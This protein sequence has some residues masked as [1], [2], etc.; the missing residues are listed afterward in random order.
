MKKIT[1]T[2]LF[3]I[4]VPSFAGLVQNGD[5]AC[6]KTIFN[7]NGNIIS[8]HNVKLNLRVNER[9]SAGVATVAIQDIEKKV[10]L[11]EYESGGDV[12]IE[13]NG[14]NKLLQLNMRKENSYSPFISVYSLKDR[15][16]ENIVSIISG[17][18]SGDF[19]IRTNRKFKIDSQDYV[20][21]Q[22]EEIYCQRL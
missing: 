7:N 14:E 2:L 8:L 19:R 21:Q 11:F 10:N 1:L 20:G 3:L 16:Y 13:N 4:S 9:E 15:S 12:L 22:E 17:E 6:N 18:D 5:Y